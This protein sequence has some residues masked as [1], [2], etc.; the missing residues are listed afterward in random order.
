MFP[1]QIL[2]DILSIQICSSPNWTKVLA[3]RHESTAAQTQQIITLMFGSYISNFLVILRCHTAIKKLYSPCRLKNDVCFL[4]HAVF[5]LHS[6]P[7]S[8][9]WCL[10]PLFWFT[11]MI[12]VSF[13]YPKE[14]YI[15]LTS[16]KRNMRK[17]E[18]PVAGCFFASY[19]VPIHFNLSYLPLHFVILVT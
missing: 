18:T 13:F 3:W 7:K 11:I 5:F 16:S 2:V 10:I 1:T 12:I 19:I 17:V 15:H 6:C 4:L 8:I 14:W 9:S